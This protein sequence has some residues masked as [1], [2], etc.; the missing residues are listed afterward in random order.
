MS[1][2]FEAAIKAPRSA[3]WHAALENEKLKKGLIKDVEDALE[4]DEVEEM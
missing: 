4:T 2:V 3:T 1:S